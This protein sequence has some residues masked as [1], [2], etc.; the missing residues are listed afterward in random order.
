[1]NYMK[2]IKLLYLADRGALLN[3]G[4]PMSGDRYFWMKLGPVLSEVHDLITEMSPPD[5]PTFWSQCISA[6]TDFVVELK[7]DPGDEELSRAEQ[8]LI[9]EVFSS[10]GDYKPFDLVRL[11]HK[12]LPERKEIQSG[13]IP[14][15]YREILQAADKSPEDV[16]EIESELDSL[17]LIESVLQT[18]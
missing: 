7:K 3:W 9:G 12:I 15:E 8:K 16:E 1:M 4:R 13:R 18:G 10:Y 5:E 17:R 11:L 14:I 2:L 6:A